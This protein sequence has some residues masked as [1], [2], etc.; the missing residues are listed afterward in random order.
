VRALLSVYDKRGIVDFA[1]ALTASGW[2][3]VS[4]GGTLATL[5][6]ARLPVLS[7]TEVTGF[8]EILDGRVKTLHPKIHGGLLARRDL[9]EHLAALARHQITPVDLIAVNLYPFEATVTDPGVAEIDAVEQI[10]IGGPAML[11]AAAKNF[12][13]VIVLTDPGDYDAVLGEIERDEL[14]CDRRRAL[15]AKAFAHLAA[16]D[17]LIASYL[18]RSD[19][20]DDAWA[21]EIT[22]A[23]RHARSLRYGENPQQRGAAYR[24]LTVGHSP[25]GVLDARQLSGPE[26]SFNNLLDADAAWGAIR[27]IE[28]PA[29]AIVKHTI[30][31]GLAARSVLA[32]AYEAALAGD[33]VSAFGGI[34]ALN[35]PVDAPTAARLAETLFHVIVAPAFDDGALARLSRKR[36]LRLLAMAEAAEFGPSQRS[37]DVRPIRGGFLL[38]DTDD[39][40]T[41]ESTWRTVTRRLPSGAEYAD[42]CFAWEAVRH[43][44]SNAVVLVKDRAVIGVG[45]GQ[46]NRL[47]SVV[48]AVKK[49]GDRAAGSVLASDAFF[50][51]A[52]GL[53]TA[54][55]AGVT[56]AVQPGGSVKD[57]EVIAVADAAGAAMIFTGVRHFRH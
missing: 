20:A 40:P 5:R 53:E 31:C 27:G 41:D 6:A 50:P 39:Q 17:A 34:V 24:R 9:P 10:D 32:E 11:R 16:Y 55:A 36:Q 33:P 35:R 14:T 13:G 45:A 47:E 46:P 3:I 21:D 7:V 23:G 4:T 22:F 52:D 43:V 15:A 2:E 57:A 19:R 49:A 8:P 28:S 54:L 44:K 26:F 56:A 51:F 29:V 25:G 30:P 38:Q 18:S 1:R 37:F 48:I 42:L 12:A